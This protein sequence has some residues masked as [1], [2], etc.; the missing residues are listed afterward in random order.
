MFQKPLQKLL[1]SQI[2]ESILDNDYTEVLKEILSSKDGSTIEIRGSRGTYKSVAGRNIALYR[3][4]IL[5]CDFN[6]EHIAFDNLHLKS[7]VEGYYN[8]NKDNI[9]K[10][11]AVFIRDENPIMHGEGAYAGIELLQSQQESWR[12]HGIFLVLIKPFIQIFE[13]PQ[14]DLLADLSLISYGSDDNNLIF[15]V[16]SLDGLNIIGV[17]KIPK[18]EKK[19]SSLYKKYE[20]LKGDYIE[21][22]IKSKRSNNYY[23]EYLVFLFQ[24]GLKLNYKSNS[25][26]AY[27]IKSNLNLTI[28]VQRR[29]FELYSTISKNKII[30]DDF[31]KYCIENNHNINLE[32]GTLQKYLK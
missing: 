11:G 20:K 4:K 3:Q 17:C 29:L 27:L 6:I 14:P 13:T 16:K 32:E 19:N 23:Y 15:L 5:N 30:R 28:N 24:N 12:T 18:I 10:N 2:E 25:F 21:R 8:K 26:N 31:I 1:N 22:I 9:N 7:L